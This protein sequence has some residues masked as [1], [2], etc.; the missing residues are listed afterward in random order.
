MKTKIIRALTG[1]EEEVQPQSSDTFELEELQKAV[2]GYIEIHPIGYLSNG[3]PMHMVINEEGK[4]K[5]L[6]V[7]GKATEIWWQIYGPTDTI[8]GDVLVCRGDQ[9]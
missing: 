5:N 8:V 6:P 2:G 1:I 9:L 7:N 3:T 4:L